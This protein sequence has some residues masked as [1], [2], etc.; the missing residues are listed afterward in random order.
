MKKLWVGL[1]LTFSTVPSAFGQASDG[2]ILGSVLDASGAGVPNANVELKNDATGVKAEVKSDADGSYRF[3]S[4]LVG[5]YTITVTAS[6][7]TVQA[8]KGV[9]VELNKTTTANFSL[10]VGAVSSTVEVTEAAALLDTTTAQISNSYERRLAADLPLAANPNGGIYNLALIGAGVSSSGGVGVGTGPSVGGQR[11]RNN[12]FTVEGVDNNNKSVTGPVIYIPNDAVAEFTVLQNQFSAEF[13]HSS[14]GQFNAIVKSGTNSLHGS[15]YEY[16]QNRDLNANDQAAARTGVLSAPRF[17][18]NR[19]GGEAGAPIIKNKLFVYGLFEYNPLG[20][21][22]TPSSTVYAP[23]A[24]GYAMLDTMAAAGTISKTNLGILE[25]YAPPTGATVRTTPVNGVAIPYGVYTIV[26]PSFSNTYNYV[27]S[28]DYNLSDK[29]QLRGRYLS[30]KTVGLDIA[31]SLP[32]FYTPQPQTGK[33]GTVSEFHSFRPNLNNEIR[34]AFNRFNADTQSPDFTYPGLDVFPNVAMRTDLNLNIGPNPSAPQAQVQ[35][36]YQIVDNV[37]WVKGRHEFKFGFDGRDLIAASTFIQRSRGDYEWNT[38]NGFLTDVFPDFI[39]QRNVGGKPY[40]GNDTAYYFFANDN[41][42]FRRN[43]TINLGVR[44]EFNGVAQSMREFG[45][46]SI[47]N[48][49]GVLTFAAPEAAKNN[50]APRIGLAYSPGTNGKTSIRAGFGMA[51]DQIFDNVGTN[52][53]PPQA[54]STVDVTNG[55][56][57]V[58]N[59]NFLK[60]GGIPP[61]ASNAPLTPTQARNQ[62]SSFLPANQQLGY[63]LT[64]NFGVQHEF[65]N[66]YTVEARYVGTK[67]VHLLFQN[68]INRNSLVTPAT[69]LPTYLQAPSAATLAGLQLTQQDFTNAKVA[70]NAAWNP[71]GA[72]GFINAITAYVPRGNSRY[73]GLAIDVKKRY[74]KNILFVMGYTFSHLID[75]STSEVS[76]IVATPRRAQDFNNLSTE[77]AN[78]ALDHRNRLTFTSVYDTPWFKDSR[79]FL[80]KN[81]L[82]GWQLS[83][84]YTVESGEWA[85]PQSGVDANENGDSAADR[86]IINT[87]GVPGTSS[88]VTGIDRT[89]SPIASATTCTVAGVKV[90]GAGCTVAYVATNPNAQFIAAG[91]G[92]YA[93]SGRNILQTPRINNIDFTIAKNIAFGERYKLQLRADMFNAVNHPQYTL[94]RVNNVRLRSTA[95]SANMF[96]PGNPLF[97]QWDQAFS[98]NPRIVQVVQGSLS[99]LYNRINKLQ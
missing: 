9:H 37:T 36:V 64:W 97:G 1:L 51:Y 30:N 94:G 15:A 27:I 92:A 39:A 98:S 63:A 3:G 80:V 11:P 7:F 46:N 69:N 59:A 96:I 19:L 54:T 34:L 79:N 78:S 31:A 48:V 90:T 25:K 70:T 83:G 21:A 13:G 66:D 68:Q 43:L 60:N 65:A 47:A 67:G 12:N 50:W 8:L 72:Y 57:G 77:K 49:P 99:N 5:Q 88:A 52:A 2:N 53:R 32:V 56:A 24:A 62:T 14:G 71:I 73:N 44:Y 87:S 95:G 81:A 55:Q 42:R 45:L 10:T 4:V 38:L 82:G 20:Q 41:F 35:T 61:S 76:S 74:S 29:D 18:E 33:L 6:G 85:T 84:T 28:S 58:P 17:D 23:T 91:L 86:A 16:L 40:S 93:N 22:G 26:A 89:G 75:D